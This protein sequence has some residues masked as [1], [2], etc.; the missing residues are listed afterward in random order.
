MGLAV[1]FFKPDEVAEA[2][3]AFHRDG[4]ICIHDA[5]TPDQLASALAGAQRV[6]AQQ[7]AAFDLEKMNRGF[8][9]E[10]RHSHMS[11]MVGGEAE[12]GP[13]A[14]VRHAGV[15][16]LLTS[17]PTPPMDLGQWRSQGVS[18]ET[19]YAIGIK[20]AVAHRRAYDP[21]ARA[22]LYVSTPGPCTS[23]LRALPYRYVRRPVRPLDTI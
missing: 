8:S 17:L 16:V 5:L 20:A 10:D 11:S 14:V 7:R 15:T 21:I 13:C 12:M 2:V 19:F 9:L 3:S 18:P 22:T 1:R 4:F 23:D 6:I